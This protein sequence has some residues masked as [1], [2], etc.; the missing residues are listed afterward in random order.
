MFVHQVFLFRAPH[1]T[2][3]STFTCVIFFTCKTWCTAFSRQH[4]QPSACSGGQQR[5]S[6]QDRVQNSSADFIDSQHRSRARQSS[7]RYKTHCPASCC[8]TC[9]A[10][11]FHDAFCFPSQFGGEVI[12]KTNT[13]SIGFMACHAVLLHAMIQLKQVQ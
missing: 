8:L 13:G 9:A 2:L 3:A 6:N 7:D 5:R 4:C 11:C 12:F 10:P 1:L